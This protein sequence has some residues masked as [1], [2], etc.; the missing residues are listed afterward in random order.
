MKMFGSLPGCPRT[1]P[2]NLSARVSVGSIFV[3][4]PIKP[5]GTANCK[6][7]SS[8]AR[9]TMRERMGLQTKLPSSP[10]ETMPGRISISS[11]TLRTPLRMEPPATPPKRLLTSSPGRFT[12]KERM[13]II[14]GFDVKSRG[15]IG[16]CV[17][18]YSQTT[19]KLYFRTALIGMIGELSA[20]VPATNFLISS[21][22][23]CACWA[24]I[25]S[26]LFCKMMMCFRRMISTAARC[27]E[28]WGCGQLSFP[29]MRRSAA[30]IT[31]APFNMVAI[32]ISCPGQSTNDTCL[33]NFQLPPSSHGT[34]S[35]VWLPKDR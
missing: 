27:S 32:R 16:T 35:G 33:S 5:P 11:P 14:N 29:A 31:A 7:F 19:S 22:C 26:T 3:P 10:L 6:R 13:M 23:A 15:G 2:T 30:S 9:V 34:T 24:L 17:Q 1:C 28:V 21:Y 20:A 18:R 25:S 12:S 4:T 8:A